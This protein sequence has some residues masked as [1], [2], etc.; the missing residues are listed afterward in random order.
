MKLNLWN[1]HAINW[2]SVGVPLRPASS[3]IANLEKVVSRYSLENPKKNKLSALLLGVTPEITNMAWPPNTHLLAVDR[4]L[5]MIR[6]VWPGNS[7]IEADAICGDWMQLPLQKKWADLVIGDGSF[8]FFSF[9]DQYQQVCQSLKKVMADGAYLILRF[10]VQAEQTETCTV[11]FDDLYNGK[12]A[13]FHVFKW[14]LA[15][16]LQRDSSQGICVGE[17]WETWNRLGAGNEQLARQLNW[18]IDEINTINSYKESDTI[19]YYPDADS[20]RE[21]FSSDFNEIGFIVDNYEL[22]DRCPLMIFE[23]N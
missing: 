7:D 10:F 14:R 11:V 4:M 6:H 2:D 19:Y 18:P 15:M 9:P 23:L 21:L 17:V 1:K 8:T 3:D 16:S 5:G 12:I 20:I 22:A 13:N